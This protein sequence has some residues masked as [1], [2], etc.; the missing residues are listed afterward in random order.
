VVVSSSG[1]RIQHGNRPVVILEHHAYHV[2][3]PFQTAN[4]LKISNLGAA[5]AALASS[6]M[7]CSEWRDAP[8]GALAK[9]DARGS[10]EHEN[11]KS[12]PIST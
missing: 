1:Q 5:V 11:Y 4:Q 12:N 6:A 2:T 7:L 8:R 3:A 9:N 10:Q